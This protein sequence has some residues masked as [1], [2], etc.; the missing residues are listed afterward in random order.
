M[1]DA[2]DEVF[3][4]GE[5]DVGEP[6]A[7][8]EGPDPFDGVEVGCVGRQVVDR[9]PVP[10]GG[11]L[12]QAGGLVDVEVVPDEHDRAAELLVGGD[13]QVPVVAPGEAFAAVASA[14]VPAWPVDQ[15]GPVA[16]FVAGQ[17]RDGY[18]SAG[19][20]TDTHHRGPAAL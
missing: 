7:S 5:G 17:R 19:T 11:E 3:G 2:L 8:Q 14:V 9:Q 13:Q 10:G 4:G 20:A 15:P 6:A 12:P 1:S 18:A 16:G